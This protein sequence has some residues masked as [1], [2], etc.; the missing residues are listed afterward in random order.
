LHKSFSYILTQIDKKRLDKYL[1]IH[2]TKDQLKIINKYL[3]TY[4]EIHIYRFN[5]VYKKLTILE[6][7]PM[8]EPTFLKIMTEYFSLNYF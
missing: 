2:F 8:G 6:I 3:S 5:D 7:N 4:A 1:L